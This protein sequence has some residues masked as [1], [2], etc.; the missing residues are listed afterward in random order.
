MG[1]CCTKSCICLLNIYW[2]KIAL[3]LPRGSCFYACHRVRSIVH[4]KSYLG[5]KFWSVPEYNLRIF[6]VRIQPDQKHHAVSCINSQPKPGLNYTIK[7]WVQNW[8]TTRKHSDQNWPK[9]AHCKPWQNTTDKNSPYY[10]NIRQ[11]NMLQWNQ[12][13]KITTYQIYQSVWAL[14]FSYC[15]I[16][17]AH[18]NI[19]TIACSITKHFT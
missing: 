8:P 14:C 1:A 9:M 17:L 3:N 2:N 5:L 12:G 10:K 6:L 19:L 13:S 4:I 15:T 11:K 7:F 18:R 16:L